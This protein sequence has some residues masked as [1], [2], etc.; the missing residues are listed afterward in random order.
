[1]RR[2]GLL[3][4]AKVTTHLPVL[5]EPRGSAMAQRGRAARALCRF[6]TLV[7]TAT[8]AAEVQGVIASSPPAGQDSSSASG[9]AVTVS[10]SVLSKTNTPLP[11]L[12]ENEFR[13]LVDDREQSIHR[14]LKK[15]SQRFRVGLL[16][17]ISGSQLGGRGRADWE[18]V[19][20]L[21]GLV[22]GKG[23]LGFV[24]AFDDRVKMM[25]DVTGNLSELET[26]TK[27]VL[28]ASPRGGTALYDAISDQ[29]RDQFW[30]TEESKALV[31]ITDG[32]DNASHEKLESAVKAAQRADV[33]IY[34]I[35]PPAP[36]LPFGFRRVGKSSEETARRI[37]AD[38]GGLFLPAKKPGDIRG[39]I[40]RIAENLMNLYAI[41][42]Y[43]QAV[44]RNGKFHK[45]KVV[46][47]RSGVRLS[48]QP[49]YYAPDK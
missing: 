16:V 49:G 14:V 34:S 22:L 24:A 48:A 13:V 12:T 47:T 7:S 46:S 37:S 29:C 39:A 9:Q 44:P 26:A 43:P 8:F 35:V 18:E 30:K 3:A 4:E 11:D 5:P 17:D 42:F 33:V 32:E 41:S 1:M 23:D 40:D 27:L 6:L 20:T 2:L 28:R 19:S 45:V 21:F 36:E 31:I 10:V 25:C 15:R 38:T